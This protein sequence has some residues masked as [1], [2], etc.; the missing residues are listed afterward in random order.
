MSST[1]TGMMLPIRIKRLIWMA[2]AIGGGTFVCGL[3]LAPER[4]WAALLT[5]SLH[6]VGLALG[7]AFFLGIQY[8]TGASWA[9]ALRRV[10]E[11]M[12]GALALG[13]VGLIAVLVFRPSLYPWMD[14]SVEPAVLLTGFKGFWLNK[15]FF[16]SRSVAYLIVWGLL[17]RAMV[18]TSHRL[19]T[20]AD[21]AL[22][23]RNIRI[24][25]GFL[26]V[27]A[28]TFWLATFDWIMSLEPLWYSSILGVYNFAG[29]FS[30][31]LA[32]IIILTVWLS[33][34]GPLRGVLTSEHLHDLGKLLF[35][36]STFW[37]YIWFS[38][39]MLIWYANFA[40]EVHYFTLRQHGAWGTLS[41]LNLFLNWVVP[42]F[43]LLSV[44]AKRSA[45]VMVRVSL[46]VLL[47]RWLD[48]YLM[49]TPPVVGA[50]S[51]LGLIEIGLMVGGVGAFLMLFVRIFRSA[52]VV[53]LSNPS[54]IESSHPSVT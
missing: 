31:A 41:F 22:A 39:Y 33:K 2:T 36:F 43:A 48:L 18:R 45:V 16:L 15:P 13:A 14:P 25:A 35:A 37:M 52:P 4:S 10:P 42:F 11:A 32:V 20:H 29:A 12:G 26:A 19:D 9:F 49:V 38:Q 1:P 24:S 53:P 34:L 3:F 44:R 5:V 23:R 6:L 46:V 51:S 50:D 30:G 21:P 54:I 17:I 28:A 8:C 40:E 47:G 7:A 27:F